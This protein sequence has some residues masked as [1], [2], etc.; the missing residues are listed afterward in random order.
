MPEPGLSPAETIGGMAD[1]N[2]GRCPHCHSDEIIWVPS[3][4]ADGHNRSGIQVGAFR[5]V[6]FARLICLDCGMVREWVDNR[7]DLDLLRRKYGK[8][9][10]Q[11]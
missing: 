4:A 3:S 8:H 7:K 1:I 6:S 5:S 10:P 2:F 9:L 11:P